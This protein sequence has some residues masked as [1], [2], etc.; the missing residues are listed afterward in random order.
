LKANGI[1]ESVT[2]LIQTVMWFL[3]S[4]ILIIVGSQQLVW[5]VACLFMIASILVSVLEN[6]KQ[7]PNIS[8]GKMEVIKEG[9]KTLAHTPVLRK[10]AMI[11]MLETVAGTVWI[12]AILYVFVNEAL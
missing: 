7:T 2:Q 8:K 11:D 6:V 5:I 4:M 12:A 10:I 1:T 3:G 9:W